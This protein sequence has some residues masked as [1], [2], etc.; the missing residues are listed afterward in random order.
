[1][2]NV[3]SCRKLEA[4]CRDQIPYLWLTGWQHPDHNTLWRFYQ[5]HRD[6]MRELF[7]RT[8]RT[9]MAM[10]LVD[11]AVQAVDGTK[12]TANAAVIQ[13]YDAKRL[14]E[15]L[16]RVESAIESLE[17]QNEGGEGGVV[18]RLPEK[19]AKRKALRQRVRQ[20]MKELPSKERPNRYKRPARINLTD[21][22]ARLMKTRQGIVPGY[23]AQAVVSPLTTDE[24]IGGMV[25]TA[26]DVVDE[27]YDAS[28]LT[29]MVKQ[30]EDSTGVRVPLTLA[31]AG[32]FAGEHVAEFHRKGQQVVMPDKARPTSH[33]YHKDQ[34]RYDEKTD[35][36]TCPHG[37]SL[38][39]AGL[40]NKETRKHGN[41]VWLR[42]QSVGSVLRSE[43]APRTNGRDA[44]LR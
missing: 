1:M 6:S 20:A 31:D 9:A 11:L 5:R 13:T 29:P 28:R 36:Y 24:G 38:T 34:F 12:V 30:A 35:S 39:F 37:Q 26:V 32:Y 3:R 8:V 14:Q 15:L 7:R 21:K 44:V 33:P 27:P 19:L 23:N 16:D 42:E 17:A 4:A 43:S 10:E 18:A 2:T 22:D 40:I 25:V 41:T